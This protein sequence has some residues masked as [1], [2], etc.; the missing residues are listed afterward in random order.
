MNS[1]AA[2]RNIAVY[3]VEAQLARVV[4]F[5]CAPSIEAAPK[6]CENRR[7]EQRCVSVIDRA[8]DEYAVVVA[9]SSHEVGLSRQWGF[10]PN[11]NNQR[12]PEPVRCI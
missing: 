12:P 9:L 2:F 1:Q 7:T 3:L 5:E 4:F 11:A 10:K 6:D 8:V